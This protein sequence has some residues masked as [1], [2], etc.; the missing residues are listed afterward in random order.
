MSFLD[1]L[2]LVDERLLVH[3]LSQL[4][5]PGFSPDRFATGIKARAWFAMF[6]LSVGGLFL[7]TSLISLIPLLVKAL[8]ELMCCLSVV[9]KFLNLRVEIFVLNDL[10]LHLERSWFVFFL[11]PEL[12]ASFSGCVCF[13]FFFDATR[14]CAFVSLVCF[15]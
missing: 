2:R 12:S 13:L 11:P 1:V 8:D 6:L 7:L 4:L 9:V 10:C 15:G 5:D 3:V 14:S